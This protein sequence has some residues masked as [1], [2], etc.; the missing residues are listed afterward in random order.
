M[1]RYSTMQL[2]PEI[3]YEGIEKNSTIDDLINKN[4][5]K[6]EKICDYIISAHIAVESY[7][8]RHSTGNY[9]RIRIALRIPPKHEIVVKHTSETGRQFE[10]LPAIIRRTFE[11]AE[12]QLESL[13][14]K[15]RNEVKAHT[16]N[17]TMAIVDKIFRDEGYGF[18]RALDGHQIYF[19]KNSCLHGEWEILRTGINVRYTEQEGEKGSQASSIEIADKRGARELHK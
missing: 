1:R 3:T 7:N 12:R 19:H 8:R 14:E 13:V 9:Y 16:R 15:Q 11:S 17:E 10:P 4:I 6:L 2:P 5:A 18:L